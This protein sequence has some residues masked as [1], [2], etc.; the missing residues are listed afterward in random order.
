VA[1]KERGRNLGKDLTKINFKIFIPFFAL[2]V[3]SDIRQVRRN[4][5]Y[6]NLTATV[7]KDTQGQ[8][9]LRTELPFPSS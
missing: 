3:P 5:S 1:L 2:R 8:F 7:G 6:K 4:L 9:G